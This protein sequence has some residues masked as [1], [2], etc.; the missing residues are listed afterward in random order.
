MLETRAGRIN[1]N[2][3]VT[4]VVFTVRQISYPLKT[5]RQELE[6]RVRVSPPTVAVRIFDA[7]FD[8]LAV[9]LSPFEPKDLPQVFDLVFLPDTK[10]LNSGS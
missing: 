10:S 4:Y 2:R 1:S 7:R 8:L 3:E 5:S 9:V 6:R